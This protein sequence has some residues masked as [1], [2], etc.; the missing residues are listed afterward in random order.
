M[1][2]SKMLLSATGAL[3]A[4]AVTTLKADAGPND[5]DLLRYP[6]PKLHPQTK[7]CVTVHGTGTLSKWPYVSRICI[8]DKAKAQDIACPSVAD[9][10]HIDELRN[11]MTTASPVVSTTTAINGVCVSRHLKAQVLSQCR[12]VKPSNSKVGKAILAEHR[13]AC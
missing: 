12:T 3:S 6:A 9:I 4:I 1:K 11:Q 5:P 13:S 7:G 2:L 8:G 10:F